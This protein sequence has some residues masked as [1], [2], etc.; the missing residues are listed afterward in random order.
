MEEAESIKVSLSNPSHL[1]L[2]QQL[3]IRLFFFKKNVESG[4]CHTGYDTKTTDIAQD[5]PK[6]TW[7][8]GHLI[9]TLLILL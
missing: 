7:M 3:I 6:Q 8:H 4:K 9:Y 5:Y 1:I 2:V